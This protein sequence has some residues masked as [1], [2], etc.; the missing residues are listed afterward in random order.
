MIYNSINIRTYNTGRYYNICIVV[1]YLLRI[2]KDQKILVHYVGKYKR[3]IVAYV[4]I[5]GTVRNPIWYVFKVSL[6]EQKR[7]FKSP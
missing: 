3:L 7:Q 6:Q 5:H 2:Q 1:L 4:Q